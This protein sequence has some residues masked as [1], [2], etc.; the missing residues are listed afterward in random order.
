MKY[1]CRMVHSVLK[2]SVQMR[3]RFGGRCE[4]HVFAEVVAASLAI[5]AFTAHDACFDGD[6]LADGKVLYTWAN[7]GH[8]SC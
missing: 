2:G 1:V 5:G 7:C 8:D 3:E 6:T 4:A